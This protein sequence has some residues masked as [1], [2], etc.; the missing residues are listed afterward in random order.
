MKAL[1]DFFGRDELESRLEPAVA[2]DAMGAEVVLTAF[3]EME[4]IRLPAALG[5]TCRGESI[6]DEG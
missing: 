6:E 5:E 1:E 4:E 2:L 3:G